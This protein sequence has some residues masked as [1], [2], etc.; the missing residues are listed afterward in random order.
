MAA[1]KLRTPVEISAVDKATAVFK[2]TFV[3]LSSIAKTGIKAVFSG[4]KDLAFAPAD[5][6]ARASITSLKDLAFAAVD[7]G[8]TL[9]DQ[10]MKTR[11]SVERI[12]E[13]QYVAKNTDV[14]V[15]NLTSGLEKFAIVGLGGITAKSGPLFAFLKKIGGSTKRGL[16]GDLIG[17]K[18]DTDKS[19]RL[20]LTALAKLPPGAQRSQLAMAAFGKANAEMALLVAKGLPEMERLAAAKRKIGMVS[21]EEAARADD[22]GDSM[23]LLKDK[24]EQLKFKIGMKLIPVIEAAIPKMEA[25]LDATAPIII[26]KVGSAVEYVGTAIDSVDWARIAG[27]FRSLWQDGSQV[28]DALGGWENVFIGIGAA[29]AAANLPLTAFIASVTWILANK[30]KT[31]NTLTD[32]AETLGIVSG[33]RET[34]QTVDTKSG[35]VTATEVHSKNM[36]PLAALFAAS[37]KSHKL[38]NAANAADFY[39]TLGASFGLP[40]VTNEQMGSYLERQGNADNDAELKLRRSLVTD[41][42]RNSLGGILDSTVKQA[43]NVIVTV[44]FRNMPEGVEGAAT[45]KTPT[46]KVVQTGTRKVGTGKL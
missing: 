42:G 44:D 26:E 35:A 3:G 9:H 29:V 32:T 43:Q 2:R 11:L 1:T 30:Q 19:L 4:L 28:V 15:D 17:A 12:Q 7:M 37:G 13:L 6:A 25:F 40:A 18:G 33:D 36:S 34:T 10:S 39:N 24:Y 46:V 31:A 23:E 16:L 27:V 45:S 8:S 14:S 41:S 38:S 20:V 22:V 21:Q 5:S